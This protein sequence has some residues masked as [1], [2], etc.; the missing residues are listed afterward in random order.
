MWPLTVW[1]TGWLSG[2]WANPPPHPPLY[3]PSW[4][5]GIVAGLFSFTAEAKSLQML[6]L[7]TGIA[8]PVFLFS[9]FLLLLLSAQSGR[10]LKGACLSLRQTHSYLADL[11]FSLLL[12]F[13]H[14]YTPG[15]CL[16]CFWHVVFVL[17]TGFI[18]L[19]RVKV[20]RCNAAII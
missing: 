10:S 20:C 17:L 7:S 3:P 9:V 6:H 11:L 13:V 16:S 12:P 5:V 8:V 18:S 15:K 14:L 2:S 1:L 4:P 19:H